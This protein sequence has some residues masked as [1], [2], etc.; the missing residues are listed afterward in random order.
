MVCAISELPPGSL[1]RVESGGRSACVANVNGEV[2]AVDNRCL[3]K[4]ASLVEGHLEGDL[5]SCP[6]HWWR[7]HMATG[8]L[9]GSEVALATYPAEV[10]DG[11]VIV[12][13]PPPVVQRSIRDILHAHARGE[14]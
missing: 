9:V 13:L 6:S 3:H 2:F 1:T 12:V 7:Y 10:V 8:Q 5:V 11:D 4:G 14:A